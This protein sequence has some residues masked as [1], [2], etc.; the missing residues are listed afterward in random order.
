MEYWNNYELGPLS[1]HPDSQRIEIRL[2]ITD[3]DPFSESDGGPSADKTSEGKVGLKIF[4]I[5]VFLTAIGACYLGKDLLRAKFNAYFRVTN[6]EALSS[7]DDMDRLF[8][9]SDLGQETTSAVSL[10]ED[11][12]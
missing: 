4:F 3:I 7:V 10:E 11:L 12:I 8:D 6:S 5:F 2:G 9:G 1:N